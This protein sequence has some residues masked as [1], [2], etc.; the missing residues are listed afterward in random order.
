ML[1]SGVISPSSSPFASPVIMVRKKDSSCRLYVDYR[2]LNL[3]TLKTKYRLPVIDELLDELTGVSWFSKL[4]LRAGYHQIRL[5]SGE[6][7]KTAFHTHNGHCQFNVLAFGL[8]DALQL[9][10][11]S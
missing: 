6:E 8:T 5:A 10:S 3:I 2:H 1:A 4:D 7:Y 9:F 11:K